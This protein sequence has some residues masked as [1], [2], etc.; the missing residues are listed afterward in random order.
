MD[1]KSQCYLV[2]N[3][4]N[5]PSL[6]HIRLTNPNSVN[7]INQEKSSFEIAFDLFRYHKK[8]VIKPDNSYEG[9]DV[10]ICDTEKD[11][12]VILVDLFSRHRFLAVSPFVEIANEFRVV[13]LD[14]NC[15]LIYKKID[16]SF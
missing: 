13:F 8:I 14:G 2:L 1:N 7:Y 9:I 10:F 5:I 6:R 4:H 16:L 12:E 11:I 3:E 15:E